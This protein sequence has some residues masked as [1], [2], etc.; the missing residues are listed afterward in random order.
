MFILSSM[1]AT[2]LFFCTQLDALNPAV[3]VLM[4]GLP[5]AISYEQCIEVLRI[6]IEVK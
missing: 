1:H 4:R 5:G 6:A 2:L 3:D